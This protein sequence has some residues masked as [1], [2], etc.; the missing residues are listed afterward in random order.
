[1]RGI[2]LVIEAANVILRHLGEIPDG[3]EVRAL[4]EQTLDCIQEAAAWKSARP[5]AQIR[6]AMMK[7]VLA[8]HVEVKR[9]AERQEP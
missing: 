6:E 8:L 5:T 7:R 2:A 4:R 9:L 1:V 3:V